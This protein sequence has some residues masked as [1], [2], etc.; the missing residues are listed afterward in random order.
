MPALADAPLRERWAG[1][2]PRTRSRRPILGPWPGRPG[3]FIANG[4][5]KIGIG[6][7][8]AVAEAMAALL[9]D[10]DSRLLPAGC[11]LEDNLA[12]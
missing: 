4:G 7:A 9:L 8:P 12:P 1:W 6:L 3:H 5:F 10:G 11:R 2:R